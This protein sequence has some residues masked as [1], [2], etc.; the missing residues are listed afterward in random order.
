MIKYH[1]ASPIHS[2][3]A[4]HSVL[5][6]FGH[7]PL[8][9]RS[10]MFTVKTLPPVFYSLLL[11]DHL[12]GFFHVSQRQP[13]CLSAKRDCILRMP[14]GGI[15]LLFPFESIVLAE[16]GNPKPLPSSHQILQIA[17]LV[18][19]Q[20]PSPDLCRQPN[21]GTVSKTSCQQS[22]H[23]HHFLCNPNLK[24]LS[25]DEEPLAHNSTNNQDLK[26]IHSNLDITCNKP[27]RWQMKQTMNTSNIVPSRL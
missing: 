19:S 2:W 17:T 21:I 20:L 12:P 3:H 25:H 14:K 7:L 22:T 23:Q 18:T 27:N 5:T 11:K 6:R 13:R 16:A 26:K 10:R 24:W 4:K 8:L 15:R 9:V 1:H